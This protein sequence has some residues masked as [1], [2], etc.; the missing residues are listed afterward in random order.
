[1]RFLRVMSIFVF[2]LALFSIAAAKE[3]KMG[4]HEV[5]NVT[6]DVP[7]HVGDVLLPAGRYVIRH[8]MEGEEHV[9]V[10]QREHQKDQFKVKCTLVGLPH[11]AV[12]D[13]VSCKVNASNERILQELIFSGDTSKHV[14]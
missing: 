9:M 12:R 11:K 5:S 7:V 2:V 14:F 13:E 6:F 4:I 1:M 10:F 3:N 8:T